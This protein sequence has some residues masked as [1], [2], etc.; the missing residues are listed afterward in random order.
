MYVIFSYV[1]IEIASLDNPSV[2][3]SGVPTSEGPL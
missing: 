1:V 2:R 3:I